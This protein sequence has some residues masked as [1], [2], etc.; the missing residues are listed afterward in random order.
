MKEFMVTYGES[1]NIRQK[2][3][4][5]LKQAEKFCENGEITPFKILDMS[6]FDCPETVKDFGNY[7]SGAWSASRFMGVIKAV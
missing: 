1:G 2:H 6:N 4:E 3:F 5:T 7:K